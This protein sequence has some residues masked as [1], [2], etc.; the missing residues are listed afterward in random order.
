MASIVRI[1]TSSSFCAISFVWNA[2]P[3]WPSL[4]DLRAGAASTSV[5]CSSSRR[6][7]CRNS[8]HAVPVR[9][10]Q[11]RC[12]PLVLLEQPLEALPARVGQLE[13]L[14][15]AVVDLDLLELVAE[16]DLLELGLA[17]DVAV[18]L[19]ARQPVQRRLGDVH[20]TGLDQRLHLSEQQRQRERPDMG[21]VDVRVGQQHHLVVARAARCRTRR[22]RR[23]RS[24]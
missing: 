23:S 20:I 8:D 24:R 22:A 16:Q 14:V 5:I 18:L 2:S 13:L 4:A 10:A 11:R 17:F 15:V 12:P 19:P 6:A 3:F 1:T 9:R 7:C 21:A